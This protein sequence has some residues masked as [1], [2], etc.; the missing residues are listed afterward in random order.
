[1]ATAALREPGAPVIGRR[2][3]AEPEEVGRPP[4]RGG[5]IGSVAGIDIYVHWSFSLLLGWILLSYLLQGAGV[6]EALEGVGFIL[7]L[8]GCVVLHELGHA[9]TARRFGVRTRDI[10][11]Y[12]IGGVARLEKIPERP[13]E[14]LLVAFAGPA[15]NVVI[16]AVL[17]GVISVTTGVPAPAELQV[18][19]GPFL[20]KLLTVNLVLAVFNLVPAFPMDGGRVLRALLAMRL[21]YVRATQYAA[22]TGQVIAVLIGVLGV[23]TNWFLLF[24]ALFVFVGAQQE[25]N[26]VRMRAVMSGVPVRAA[27][28]T[29][30]DTLD[31]EDT[32]GHAAH[33]L[34]ASSQ[35]DFP[36][37]VGHELVGIL[38]RKQLLEALAAGAQDA[39]VASV[40]LRTFGV[41]DEREMLDDAFARMQA[42]ETAMVPV[43]SRGE[44]CG[45]L[46]LENVGEFLM[47]QSSLPAPGE[48]R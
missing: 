28:I 22:T 36:V 45:L 29:H 13:V 26:F 18:V 12:P 33:E 11:L 7:T 37:V 9:L 25:S 1:M 8:F 14:E 6:L 35:H 24:I 16:A 23:F 34:L 15:V 39:R 32:I 38:P 17:F 3:R 42:T 20:A 4:R 44:L 31:A 21:D 46:T 30:F 41:V 43:L 27:M 40:M 47:I 5:R 2:Q 10:T 48:R 19:G